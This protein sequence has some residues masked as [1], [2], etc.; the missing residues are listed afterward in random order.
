MSLTWND[1]TPAILPWQTLVYSTPPWEAASA[2]L[3]AQAPCALSRALLLMPQ[4]YYSFMGLSLLA[5]SLCGPVL[6]PFMAGPES[7]ALSSASSIGLG[8]QLEHSE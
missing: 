8:S 5:G 1:L 7:P 3:G 6:T 2:V 4:H